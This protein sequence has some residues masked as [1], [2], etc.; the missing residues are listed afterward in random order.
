MRVEYTRRAVSQL[1]SVYEYLSERNPGAARN[2]RSSIR[3]TIDWL[4]KLP[5]LG[6][7]TDEGDVHVLIEPTYLYRVFY[8]VRGERELITVIRI[9]HRAQ[10]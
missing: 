6:K 2:M 4:E 10:D 5:L 3:A 9:L 1:A 7:L 8:R